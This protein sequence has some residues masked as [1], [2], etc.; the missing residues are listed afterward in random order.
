VPLWLPG[1]V[2]GSFMAKITG[3]SGG[4]MGCANKRRK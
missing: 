3:I 4:A 2:F 1:L